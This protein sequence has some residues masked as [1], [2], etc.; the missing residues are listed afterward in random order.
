MKFLL[1]DRVTYSEFYL[2]YLCKNTP[3]VFDSW[4]TETW[5]VCTEWRAPDGGIN[6]KSVFECVS[7][8][9]VYVAD[10]DALEFDSHPVRRLSVTEFLSYWDSKHS[11]NDHR[12][13]Y[14]KDWH[15]FKF[16][17]TCTLYTVPDYFSSDW[18]NEFWRFRS[19][20]DDDFRFVYLGARGTWTPL[21]VD[22][23]RSF[24]WS[25]NVVGCK[26]WWFFPPGEEEKLRPMNGRMPCDV[27]AIDID[28]SVEFYVVDQLP[29]Q[30]VF[31][32]SGWYHQVENITDCLS[33]NH[34]WLNATNVF[35]V[36]KH[37]QD[38]L[39]V[40]ERATEDVCS[41]PGWHEECQACL[42]A[43]TGLNFQEFFLLLKYILLTR[44]PNGE[45]NF[46]L[47][48][49]AN[50]NTLDRLNHFL[51]KQLIKYFENDF[52]TFLYYLT[53]P[54]SWLD[55]LSIMRSNTDA[56]IRIHDFSQVCQLLQKFVRHSVV[57]VLHL[58]DGLLKLFWDRI[59]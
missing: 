13:L 38:Q 23:Y 27:R 55:S 52:T 1:K 20:L 19:D 59:L 36:W 49:L 9:D 50:T 34:N 40:V 54:H 22:V 2:N 16:P 29:N 33:I 10:C 51:D 39:L 3:C 8:C 32:P 37:L 26:R 30:V 17:S 21:H 45:Q 43:L 18:L 41:T 24:S 14:L 25:A 56:W 44:W 4:L 57:H 5:P 7:D 53:N 46:L 48:D 47:T 35:E 58:T 31:V 11:S 15:Y 6:I 42:R 28:K 12:S